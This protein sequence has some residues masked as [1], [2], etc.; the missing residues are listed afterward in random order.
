MSEIGEDSED[1]SLG[2]T[3]FEADDIE[4]EDDM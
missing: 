2:M 1:E 4:L 3:S